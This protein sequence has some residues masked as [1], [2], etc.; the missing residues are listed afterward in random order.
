MDHTVYF[1]HTH[2]RVIGYLKPKR[3]HLKAFLTVFMPAVRYWWL[4][5][6]ICYF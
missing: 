3:P 1:N 6:H 5:I 2:N 4:Q